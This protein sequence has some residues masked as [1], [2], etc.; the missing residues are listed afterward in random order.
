[1]SRVRFWSCFTHSTFL[2]E[3]YCV[4]LLWTSRAMTRTCF[5]VV[6]SQVFDMFCPLKF[7]DLGGGEV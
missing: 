6:C 1:M 3:R 7:Q 4:V 2:L 5:F